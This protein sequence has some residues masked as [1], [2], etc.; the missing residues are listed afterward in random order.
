MS[1]ESNY[2]PL[3]WEK[4]VEAFGGDEEMYRGMIFKFDE[5]TFD[6]ALEKID[7]AIKF[8]N[9]TTVTIQAE[10]ISGACSYLGAQKMEALAFN[11]KQAGKSHDERVVKNHYYEFLSEARALKAYVSKLKGTKFDSSTIDGYL[12]PFTDG[13]T[14]FEGFKA[15]KETNSVGCCA[16]GV[17][18]NIF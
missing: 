10:A 5:F 7:N 3:D 1:G 13:G 15:T 14:R 17:T 11:L 4:G 18:C 2:V 16:G 9:W 6:E 12:K 8:A